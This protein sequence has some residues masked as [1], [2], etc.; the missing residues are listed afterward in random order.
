MNGG[1]RV[2][3]HD[4]F[5]ATP[6][7]LKFMKSEVAENTAVSQLVKR[8]VLACPELGFTLATGERASLT[9]PAVQPGDDEGLR[10]RLSRVMG[11]DFAEGALVLGTEREGARV[12]GFAGPP[13]LNRPTQ[14]SQYLFVNGR[15]VKDRLLLAALRA[16]YG[17]MVPRGRHPMLALFLTVP[18]EEV[19]VNVHPAKSEVRFRDGGLVRG[20]VVSG[21]RDAL[22]AGGV[23]ASVALA[24]EAQALASAAMPVHSGRTAAGARWAQRPAPRSTGFAEDWQMP[25]E[26]LGATAVSANA[27]AAASQPEPHAVD[28]PLGAARAQLHGTYIVA[29]TADAVVIVD[30]HAA[31]ER[32]VYEK[33]KAALASGGI[34]RQLLLIP[35][36]VELDTD[37]AALIET[38]AGEMERLGLGVEAFGPG[39]VL[40]REVPALLARG[41]I[42]ALIA[43]LADELAEIGTAASLEDRLHEILARVACHGSVRAGRSLK[44]EEMNALLREM[45]A[46]PFSAQ[47]NHGRPAFIELKL[48]D[49]EKLF[50][51]R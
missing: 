32:L 1:T 14:S 10:L 29:E 43:D 39:A 15:P 19:D 38:R 49:I 47:C 23:R 24:E 20:L 7:R 41:N 27:A 34:E 35:E 16:A 5:Y 2:E 36:V 28:Y 51:R 48:A 37:A 31:H 44:P 18:P 40:V 50:D 25:L 42:K 33:L 13:S 22:A 46:T 17:D 11:K 8:F 45:E 12:E 6:A 30:Q 4:L 26:G 3:V 21:I 9:F